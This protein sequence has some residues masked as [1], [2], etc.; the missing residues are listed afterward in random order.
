VLR[1][2][3]VSADVFVAKKI[4]KINTKT[5]RAHNLRGAAINVLLFHCMCLNIV[6]NMRSQTI[7]VLRRPGI[8]S[9]K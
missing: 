4:L 2:Y 1:S 7:P 9:G 6:F 3:A 8:Y 5:K